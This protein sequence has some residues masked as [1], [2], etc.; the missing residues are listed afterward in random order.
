VPFHSDAVQAAVRIDVDINRARLSLLSLSA[1][2]IYGP[3]GIGALFARKR[4]GR[5]K[6][7]RSS[8]AG[9]KSA[10][11]DQALSTCQGSLDSASPLIS[12]AVTVSQMRFA[13][14]DSRR[15]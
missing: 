12:L 10:T 7:L 1:H 5:V 8:M 11:C 4:G 3:K 2:K 6:M 15:T 13:S 9:V 14:S